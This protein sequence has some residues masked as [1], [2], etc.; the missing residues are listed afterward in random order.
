MDPMALAWFDSPDLESRP[1]IL[2]HRDSH[3]AGG[4]CSGYRDN[5]E[6]GEFQVHASGLF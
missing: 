1:A 6:D 2:R 5:S 3:N 4:K